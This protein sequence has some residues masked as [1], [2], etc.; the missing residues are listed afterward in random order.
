VLVSAFYQQHAGEAYFR[1][2]QRLTHTDYSQKELAQAFVSIVS[3]LEDLCDVQTGAD[4]TT[5]TAWLN[6]MQIAQ[7]L[8]LQRR[9]L[10][11]EALT[12]EQEALALARA[13]TLSALRNS[14]SLTPE[15]ATNGWYVRTEPR[16]SLCRVPGATGERIAPAR[17]MP[18]EREAE[19]RAM[20]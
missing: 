20:K 10:S 5:L 18:E 14:F 2:A 8:F 13:R 6:Q 19:H 16:L 4:A 7:D 3:G 12:A 15:T 11:P 1:Q 17:G 9:E